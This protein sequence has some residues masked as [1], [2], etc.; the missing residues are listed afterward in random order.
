MVLSS[1]SLCLP[2]SV[3][4]MYRCHPPGTL[5]GYLGWQWRE[6]RTAGDTIRDLKAQLPKADESGNRP[7]SPLDAQ[8]AELEAKRKDLLAQNPRDKHH[9]SGAWLLAM[10]VGI[11]IEGCVNTYMRTGRLFPGPHLFAGATC[12][13]LWALA[14]AQVPAMQKGDQTAR[15]LH[16]GLNVANLG[17]F[18]WQLPTG[19]EIV[20]KVFQVSWRS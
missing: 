1:E 4:R 16:I 5:S 11:A 18:A 19:F 14:A 7:A 17:L 12:V 2:P 8:I 6:A 13:A 9:S 3:Q 10:G 20:D 15:N